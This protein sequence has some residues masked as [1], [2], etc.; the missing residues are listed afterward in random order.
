MARVM[1][2]I[3]IAI[4]LIEATT[5]NV[6]Q[7]DD[8]YY[9]IE[10]NRE[11]IQCKMCPPGTFWIENC[12]QDGGQTV[13]QDCPDGRFIKDYNRAIYCKRCTECKGTYK[14]SGEVVADSCTRFQNTKC[15]CKPGYWRE[16]GIVGDC[17]EVSPCLPGF[18]VKELAKSHNNTTCERCVNGKTFSNISSK[19]TPCQNCSLCLEGWMQKSP[20][21]ETVDTVCIPNDEVEEYSVGHHIVGAI[22]GV[23]FA[24][25]IL[26]GIII[27]FC[28]RERTNGLPQMLHIRRNE[29]H[30]EKTDE[31]E[32]KLLRSNSLDL[33]GN[34]IGT[35]VNETPWQTL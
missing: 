12:S 7:F 23:I 17:R 4:R 27:A 9:S 20:C 1:I 5:E 33:Q 16:N 26:I 13:C 14:E 2:R 31:R 6:T 24:V 25:A 32:K 18:G 22:C 3:T 11:I 21:T 35:A 28:C 10:F 30:L 15:I 34:H 29:Q 8:H 19:V